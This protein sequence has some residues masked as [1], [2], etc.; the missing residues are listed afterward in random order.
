MLQRGIAGA[1]VP[2]PRRVQAPTPGN[3]A[4]LV[5]ARTNWSGSVP[6]QPP[7]RV[8]PRCGFELLNSRGQT[9]PVGTFDHACGVGGGKSRL[10]HRGRSSGR[11]PFADP[12]TS[13][14]AR[15]PPSGENLLEHAAPVPRRRSVLPTRSALTR[16]GLPPG[17]S[18]AR[19]SKPAWSPASPTSGALSSAP[20]RPPPSSSPTTRPRGHHLQSRPVVVR[21]ARK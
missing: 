11:G 10:R 21:V 19:G 12:L 2:H 18:R 17:V 1:P 6:A 5:C 8:R 13:T 16:G 20:Q 4:P 9:P 15:R 3:S 7:D 14:P